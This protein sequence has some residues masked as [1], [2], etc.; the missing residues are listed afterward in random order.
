MSR[1]ICIL[2]LGGTISAS[3]V[4]EGRTV[5]LLGD[6]LVAATPGL[7]AVDADLEVHDLRSCPSG[8]LTFD[9][10]LEVLH[11]AR[12]SEADGIVVVQ[13]TD[14]LEET[15]YFV[16]LFWGDDRPVVF[17]GAMRGPTL[18]GPDGAANLLAAVQ[19]AADDRF[20]GLGVLL[21]LNDEIHAARFVA[22]RHSTS[23]STFVSPNAGPL[24]RL[25]EGEPRLVTTVPRNPPLPAPA[26]VSA[27]VPLVVT[28]LGDDGTILEALDGCDGLV[29]AG[30][31]AGHVP[32]RLVERLG[33]LAKRM[34][35]V[36]ASRTGAGP[37]LTHT[38]FAPGAETD[39]IARG[40]IPAGSLDPYKARLLLLALLSTGADHQTIA[41]AYRARG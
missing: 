14:T 32:D 37:V 12:A 38:Y 28:T 41:A 18:A 16:D 11:T 2:F 20:R 31:G 15:A 4:H 33:E 1:T 40:L 19:T 30:F 23:P 27:R 25:A 5:R 39:L 34:P 21:V 36:L 7:A 29:V 17:T 22:K 13:G 8:S 9:H 6:Q 10:L 24:G 3:T 26:R 35:V